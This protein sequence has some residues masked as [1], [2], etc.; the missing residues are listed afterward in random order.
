MISFSYTIATQANMN[1]VVPEQSARIDGFLVKTASIPKN[2]T[3][4]GKFSSSS[5]IGYVRTSYF[6]VDLVEGK[7]IETSKF[8]E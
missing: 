6:I 2:H 3:T 4:L 5:E 8:V 7:K 1:Q